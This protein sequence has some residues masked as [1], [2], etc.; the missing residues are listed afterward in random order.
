LPGETCQDF[1]KTLRFIKEAR[2]WLYAVS[3]TSGFCVLNR[4]TTLH[5]D[6]AR[7]NLEEPVHP[8]Y[9]RT[10]DGSNDYLERFRRF[11]RFCREAKELGYPNH[12]L[13][14]TLPKQF[15][16]G[17]YFLFHGDKAS[18]KRAFELSL[19][20]ELVPEAARQLLSQC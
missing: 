1:E 7:Y 17:K 15:L 6:A 19:S 18:A 14:E 3:P 2:P 5:A 20:R 4:H 12:L 10:R 9:W 16:L 13:D 11:E 8:F